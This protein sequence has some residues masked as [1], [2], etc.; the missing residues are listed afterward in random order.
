MYV[1]TSYK[2]PTLGSWRETSWIA[3][4]FSEHHNLLFWLLT[5]QFNLNDASS[6]K[7][8]NFFISFSSSLETI[9]KNFFWYSVCCCFTWLYQ[10]RIFFT[11]FSL[12]FFSHYACFAECWKWTFLFNRIHFTVTLRSPVLRDW[13]RIFGDHGIGC[14]GENKQTNGLQ[15]LL[16]ERTQFPMISD[17]INVTLCIVMQDDWKV[18]TH[19]T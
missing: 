18:N 10:Y 12:T 1:V 16:I 13:W 11:E 5:L 8:T 9:A 14:S 4:R 3:W 2:A 7:N 15:H 19:G 6:K 17:V